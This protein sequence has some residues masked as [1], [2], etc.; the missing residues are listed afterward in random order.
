MKSQLIP[1]SF[2]I[3]S[4]ALILIG[5]LFYNF[6]YGVKYES[7]VSEVNVLDTIRNVIESLKNYLQLSLVYSSHQALRE[8]ASAGGMM[9]A[10]TWICNNP[11]PPSI[12]DSKSCLE[13]YT[14]YYFNIYFNLYNI[15]LPLLIT[16]TNFEECKYGVD[17][18][19]VLS[20]KYDEGNFWINCTNGKIFVS[21]KESKMYEDLNVDYYITKN[22]YWF[23]FRIFYEWVME[24]VYGKCICGCCLSCGDESC[25][26][27]CA[28]LAYEDLQ[29]R[30]KKYGDEVKCKKPEKICSDHQL[31][32]ISCIKGNECLN[33]EDAKCKCIA[34]SCETPK[35]VS[36]TFSIFSSS[37]CSSSSDCCDLY[38]NN[39][40]SYYY[41]CGSDGKC[42][43]TYLKCPNCCSCP[44]AGTTSTTIPEREIT[45]RCEYWIENRLAAT[46]SFTCEDHKYYIPSKKGPIPLTF[47]VHATAKFRCPDVC[48][49]VM[50]CEYRK[51]EDKYV[52][53]VCPENECK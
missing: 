26:E 41:Y 16:K 25:A 48:R 52:C 14:T 21:S 18:S 28:E 13:K 42:Y 4:V 10:G 47:T 20:G 19:E 29:N 5:Y 2:F 1:L 32:G 9:P 46:Y 38:C 8:H 15:S 44:N 23:M 53:P 40:P 36:S 7:Y 45:S 24:N 49:N 12:E 22:R 35:S 39:Y 43:A 27:K 6:F 31:G 11:T 3:L 50:N 37:E 30:F 33:W 51:E 34:H 17:E